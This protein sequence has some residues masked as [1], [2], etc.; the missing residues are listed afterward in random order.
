MP[1]NNDCRFIGNITHPPHFRRVGRSE[2]P[3]LRLYLAVD[4]GEDHTHYLRVVAYG[5]VALQAHPYLQ[6]G[7]KILVQTR[8]RQRRRRDRDEI[9]HEFVADHIVFIDKI[10]WE[11]GNAAKARRHTEA[12]PYRTI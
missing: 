1:W 10:D 5:D 7:S 6:V 9:V 12:V 11:R 8:Y 3:F 2:I 4:E